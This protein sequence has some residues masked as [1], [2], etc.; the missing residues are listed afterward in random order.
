MEEVYVEDPLIRPD[1]PHLLLARPPVVW[2]GGVVAQ[3]SDVDSSRLVWCHRSVPGHTE[4]VRGTLAA[5]LGVRGS[6]YGLTAG[7]GSRAYTLEF[8]VLRDHFKLVPRDHPFHQM[9]PP[10]RPDR[11]RFLREDACHLNA[12]AAAQSVASWAGAAE[13]EDSTRERDRL[14]DCSLTM[15]TSYVRAARELTAVPCPNSNTQL[16]DVLF[17]A[18]VRGRRLLSDPAAAVA[19]SASYALDGTEPVSAERE[20]GGEPVLVGEGVELV[21]ELPSPVEPGVFPQ[22]WAHH[23]S[24]VSVRYRRTVHAGAAAAGV[25]GH[26]PGD[27]DLDYRVWSG[28]RVV[29]RPSA[30]A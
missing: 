6:R 14:L 5:V 29:S 30:Q 23:L 10:D 25:S 9:R 26:A 22:A 16:R 20:S 11:E 24:S 7:Y 1:A 28:N 2:P 18:L 4:L 21:T 12:V 3:P 19:A 8:E 17:A 13:D 27:N 15:L